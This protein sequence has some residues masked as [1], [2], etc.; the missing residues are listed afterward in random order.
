MPATSRITP[1]SRTG[2][3]FQLAAMLGWTSA[4]WLPL[5]RCETLIL[6]GD[7]DRLVPPI[8]GSFLNLLIPH[9]RLEV[10]RGGGHLFLMAEADLCVQLIRTFLDA[11]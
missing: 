11:P 1:P 9:S 7:D 6:M 3:F 8:N 5:L 4:P 10:I 2:Y